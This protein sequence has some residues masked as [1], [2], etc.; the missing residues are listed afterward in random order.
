MK[1]DCEGRGE[2][3]GESKRDAFDSEVLEE[4]EGGSVEE[5]VENGNVEAE[6]GENGERAEEP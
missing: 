3:G 5:V 6:V 4:Q 1:F 2:P